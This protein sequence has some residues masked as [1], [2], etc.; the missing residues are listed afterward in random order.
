MKSIKQIVTADYL[1]QLQTLNSFLKTK[2]S[3]ILLHFFDKHIL[4]LTVADL[5]GFEL[6]STLPKV[7]RNRKFLVNLDQ[8]ITQ[9][10]LYVLFEQSEI[11]SDC[12]V[13]LI[14]N[15]ADYLG[16]MEKRVRSRFNR[17]VVV[18]P[19]VSFDT[20]LRV[21]AVCSRE[22]K[23]VDLS[24]CKNNKRKTKKK[25]LSNTRKTNKKEYPTNNKL[26][27]ETYNNAI[28][29]NSAEEHVKTKYLINP[30]VYPLIKMHI[31]DEFNI[32]EYTLNDTLSILSPMHLAVLLL[33]RKKKILLKT[34]IS[35]YKVYVSRISELR[36]FEYSE[37]YN[38][39]MDIKD[40]ELHNIDYQLLKQFVEKN[41]PIYLRNLLNK[42]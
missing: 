39:Y 32:P 37:L 36:K 21:Y 30:T 14:T 12:Q 16:R 20:Y 28:L 8:N 35:E 23:Q 33:T 19:F 6:I 24:S 1:S 41:C 31:R 3:H 40:F 27:S 11:L 10:L 22:Q 7:F 18:F 2:N 34:L 17:N 5:K 4:E 42:L 13:V 25:P 26:P 29:R 38:A 15:R 9:S